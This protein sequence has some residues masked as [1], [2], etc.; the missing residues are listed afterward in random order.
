MIIPPPTKQDS[1]ADPG[2]FDEDDSSG[3]DGWTY[4]DEDEGAYR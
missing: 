4:D 3:D 1:E 2:D